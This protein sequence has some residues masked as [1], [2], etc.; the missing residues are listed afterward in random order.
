[1]FSEGFYIW[2]IKTVD[3]V[4]KSE[5]DDNYLNLVISSLTL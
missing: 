5:S 2:V 3:C 4:V 1:M